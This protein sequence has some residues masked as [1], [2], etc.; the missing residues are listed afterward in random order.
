MNQGINQSFV[1]LRIRGIHSNVQKGEV[2]FILSN[3]IRENVLNQSI[4][5]L[6]VRLRNRGIHSLERVMM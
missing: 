1:R 2:I 3:I 6:F 5:Q 4:H